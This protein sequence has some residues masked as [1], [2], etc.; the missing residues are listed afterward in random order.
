MR[1]DSTAPPSIPGVPG[2]TPCAPGPRPPQGEK[3]LFGHPSGLFVLFF[4]EMWERFSYYGMRAL[5]VYYMTKHLLLSQEQSSHVYGL[6]CGLVYF[7]PFL[8]GILADRWLGRSR[9]VVAGGVIMAAGHFLMAFE[10]LFY[11]ALLLLV[12]GNG[13]FKP[14]ISAQVGGL[15]PDG[16]PRRDRAFSI[17]YVGINL[18]AFLAPL[19]CGT[20]GEMWGWHYGFGAAGV[21]MLIGLG[22]YVFGRSRLPVDRFGREQ[23]AQD[24]DESSG[25]DRS[26]VLGLVAVCC[27]VVLFWA[28]YEQSGNTLALWADQDTDRRIFGWEMPA[29]WFQA[30]NPFLIFT[31]TPLVT[32]LWAWQS[33]RCREPSSAAKIGLGLFLAGAAFLVMVYPGLLYARDGT[34]VSMFWLLGNTVL[35]TL[36]ELYLSPVGLSLVT[37]LA[38]RRMVSMFMGVWFMAQFAGNMAAGLLG[39]LWTSLP[40]GAFFLILAGVALAA[41]CLVLALLRPLRRSL[42]E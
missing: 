15:Y 5:L 1:P 11:P 24:G 29:S 31:L 34:P 35:L 42:G 30:F 40:Q 13:A 21:G 3:T 12:A 18:G 36:G 7:T 38:P 26:R 20:L 28:V 19:V 25:D 41:G 16:D 32:S 14:N 2:S 8:G 23:A 33:A 6:Y 39:G 17:F 4:T 9:C 10:P 27:I 22:V 37:K